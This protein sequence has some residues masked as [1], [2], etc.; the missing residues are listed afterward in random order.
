MTRTPRLYRST[1][2]FSA[3]VSPARIRSARDAPPWAVADG[4]AM[5][6]SVYTAS[7]L[8]PALRKSCASFGVP[9]RWGF[10]FDPRPTR[11]LLIRTGAVNSLSV[12]E[13]VT[14]ATDH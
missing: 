4:E 1:K 6:A 5:A 13:N 9:D 12:A 8:V 10:R 14:I 7:A 3:A 11:E 2:S